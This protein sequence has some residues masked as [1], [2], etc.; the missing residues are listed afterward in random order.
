MLPTV[1][2]V[3]GLVSACASPLLAP[4]DRSHVCHVEVDEKF[5][6]A[7]FRPN[8]FRNPAGAAM[9]AAMGAG[10][11]VFFGPASI[12]AVPFFSVLFA[13][14]GAACG[15]QSLSHPD[16]EAGFEKILRTVDTGSL[17]RALQEDLNAPRGG[18]VP[19]KIDD[20][21]RVAP[22]AVIE[23]EKLEVMMACGGGEQEYVVWVTWRVVN[24]TNHESLLLLGE[25]TTM[26]SQTSLRGVDEWLADPDS[27]RV[28]IERMLAKTGQHMAADMLSSRKLTTCRFRSGKAG[29]I[30]E[31]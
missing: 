21:A 18:C 17:K 20:S 12:I 15:A 6:S 4:E 31:R 26:C 14:G 9:G 22:D 2:L 1:L 19:V 13:A 3:V 29:E 8:P 7:I 27:A 30:E 5:G 16:A 25:N 24:A 10:A 28:E 23:I 11:G